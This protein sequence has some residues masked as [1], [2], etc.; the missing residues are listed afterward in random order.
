L[1]LE[2]M[3]LVHFRVMPG[4]GVPFQESMEA[5]FSLQKEGKILH[6]GISNVSREELQLV[7]TMGKIATVENMYGHGQRTTLTMH[8]GESRG[9]EEVLDICEIGRAS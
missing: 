9:G 7:M 2:Q 1:K 4:R 3:P 5:M 8:N 6:V